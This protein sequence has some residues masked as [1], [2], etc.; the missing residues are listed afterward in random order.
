MVYILFHLSTNMVGCDT[1]DVYAI[2]EKDALLED[3]SLNENYLNEIGYEMARDYAESYGI[4]KES[5][6]EEDPF[7]FSFERVE[8]SVSEI[9]SEYG[10]ILNL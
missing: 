6:D 8:G 9:E 5:D 3:G 10:D 2:P 4:E 1:D 7:D